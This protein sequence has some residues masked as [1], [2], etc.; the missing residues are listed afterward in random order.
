MTP[1]QMEDLRLVNKGEEIV[2]LWA[3]ARRAMRRGG[4]GETEGSYRS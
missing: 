1:D 4:V 2:A 3:M